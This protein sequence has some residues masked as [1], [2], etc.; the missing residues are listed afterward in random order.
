MPIYGNPP[1]LASSMN[2]RQ[3]QWEEFLRHL[4]GP[5][6][7]NYRTDPTK[8]AILH[9]CNVDFTHTKNILRLYYPEMDIEE[10]ILQFESDGLECDCHI[11]CRHFF[12]H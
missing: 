8:A 3:P 2:P 11:L 9:E 10:T 7:C 1:S 6:G 5:Q 12:G 4:Y